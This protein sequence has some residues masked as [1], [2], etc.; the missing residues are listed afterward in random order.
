EGLDGGRREGL[1][2]EARPHGARIETRS[3]RVVARVRERVGHIAWSQG[4]GAVALHAAEL[5][6]GA[7]GLDG[8]PGADS[9]QRHRGP[10]TAV[11]AGAGGGAGRQQSASAG[12]GGGQGARSRARAAVDGRAY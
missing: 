4:R 8:E 9:Q 7:A 10:W 3:A 6:F 2:V 12:A 1:E 11:A 5:A